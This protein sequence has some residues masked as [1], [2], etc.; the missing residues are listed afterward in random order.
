[1]KGKKNVFNQ[2]NDLKDNDDDDE[3]D[4][5][6][7]LRDNSKAKFPHSLV[8]ISQKFDQVKP[9]VFRIMLVC[10]GDLVTEKWPR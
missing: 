5:K 3:N 4:T 10:D 6:S 2:F 9:A 1:M 8:E 7:L